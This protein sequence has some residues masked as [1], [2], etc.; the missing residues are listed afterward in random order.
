MLESLIDTSCYNLFDS[1]Y[2]SNER[3]FSNKRFWLM[4][5]SLSLISC[6]VCIRQII[7]NNYCSPLLFL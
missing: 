5:R 1:I 7:V 6:P 2:L 3:L 4:A